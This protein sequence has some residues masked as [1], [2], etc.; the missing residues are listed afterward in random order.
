MPN[1]MERSTHLDCDADNPHP[2]SQGEL[3]TENVHIDDGKSIEEKEDESFASG[4]VC[5]LSIEFGFT[6]TSNWMSLT[7]FLS[8][9]LS[10]LR[11]KS[12]YSN[13]VLS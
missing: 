13:Q 10:T 7:S 8:Q 3:L 5:L 2:T 9:S 4:I 11:R 6:H 12:L 1:N